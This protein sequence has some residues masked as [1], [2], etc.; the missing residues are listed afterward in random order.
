MTFDNC[1]H[2][3][4]QDENHFPSSSFTHLSCTI[5]PP[6]SRQALI[7]FLSLKIRFVFSK[8]L[9]K[10]SR[11]VHTPGVWLPLLSVMLKLCHVVACVSS[12]CIA[13]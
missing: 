5:P 6:Q 7:C 2:H 4:K 10:C 8:T 11:T 13:H 1:M 9:Y 12:V 3:Y